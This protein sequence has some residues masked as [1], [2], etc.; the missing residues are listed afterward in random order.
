MMDEPRTWPSVFITKRLELAL[1]VPKPDEISYRAGTFRAFSAALSTVRREKRNV[2]EVPRSIRNSGVS[3]SVIFKN[4][5]S[6]FAGYNFKTDGALTF[7]FDL[8]KSECPAF[9]G[10]DTASGAYIVLPLEEVA[11]VAALAAL[12]V[13]IRSNGDSGVFSSSAVCDLLVESSCGLAILRSSM[14]G[15][16]FSTAVEKLLNPTSH[17]G[18]GLADI[19]VLLQ[20]WQY[21]GK[22]L[23]MR[24]PP[25]WIV[26]DAP[27]ALA[28]PKFFASSDGALV[29]SRN[30]VGAILAG[31][32]DCEIYATDAGIRAGPRGDGC[33]FIEMSCLFG[34]PPSKEK[35]VASPLALGCKRK[36]F[37]EM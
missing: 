32:A 25:D 1:G 33:A 19:L 12:Q 30:Q 15:S 27:M 18:V 23:N 3:F 34:A 28:W 24:L 2:C 5:N 16:I 36:F 31:A 17:G 37:F 22:V 8:A 14:P 7:S 13:Y 21:H 6:V 11:V 29:I 9:A 4:W 35:T 26:P 10:S 20:D